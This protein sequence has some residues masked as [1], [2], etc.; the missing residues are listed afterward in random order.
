M[1]SSNRS[2]ERSH[3][4]KGPAAG[5]VATLSSP[6][7][8]FAN[9]AP[10]RQALGRM[11]LHPLGKLRRAHQAGLH[12]DVSEVRCDR[13]CSWQFAGDETL[14]SAAMILITQ[15]NAVATMGIG[16]ADRMTCCSLAVSAAINISRWGAPIQFNANAPISALGQTPALSVSNICPRNCF[17]ETSRSRRRPKPHGPTCRSGSLLGSEGRRSHSAR[18]QAEHPRSDRCR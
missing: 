13:V 3:I 15:Q 11:L 5:F 6:A 17:G 18:A 2:Q 16:A 4:C 7:V 9:A 8:L 14:Q 1:C 12:R 10:C